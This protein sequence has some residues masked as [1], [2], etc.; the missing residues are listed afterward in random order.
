[1]SYAGAVGSASSPGAHAAF[2]VASVTKTFVAAAI[3][4]LVERDRLGLDDVLA[5][6]LPAATLSLLETGGYTPRE[7]TIRHL[8][9]HTSGLW[10]YAASEAYQQAIASAP[11]HH[12]TRHEQLAF[13][14]THGTPLG[15]PGAAFAYSDTGYLL[16][17]A[18]LEQIT[19]LSW[20]AAVRELVDFAAVGLAS[21]WVE[22]L[23][24]EPSTAPPRAPQTYGGVSLESIDPS[25][26]LWGGGGLVSTTQDLARFYERLFSDGVFADPRTLQTM[27][28]VPV[29]NQESGYAM[30]VIVAN[31]DG[32]ACYLHDG[33]WG[34]RALTCPSL[35]VTAVALA[36]EGTR[37]GQGLDA[38]AVLP[39]AMSEV[40]P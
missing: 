6:V 10:D 22:R 29:P 1:V 33:F 15:R 24:P 18:V 20:A 7:I 23:E 27:V 14:M 8:L 12:W 34:V 31:V 25:V 16:L 21:T 4:R 40:C 26:D 3:L 36:M 30:G 35:G 5:T 19:G 39:I 17:A 38:L 9:T 11:E 37:I 32:H 2:R 13:A 28:T